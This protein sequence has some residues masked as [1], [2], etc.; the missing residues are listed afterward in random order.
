MKI[1]LVSSAVPLVFGGGRFISEWLQA[2]LRKRGHATEIVNIPSTD[3]PDTLLQQMAAF[4]SIDLSGYERVITFRPPAHVVRHAQKVV[5]FIHH[6]RIFYDL[7]DTPYRPVPDTVRWR[8][9]RAQLMQSDAAALSEARHV[10]SNSRVV[11]DRLARFNGIHAEVL[12]PPVKSSVS[13]GWSITSGNICWCK[14]W[15]IPARRSGCACVA[16]VLTRPMWQACATRR[17]VWV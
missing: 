7:W 1:G 10:F 13:A 2:E 17:S 9:L 4:R 16:R 5:W 8:A 6:I 12:Y 3:N 14:P 11:A 15:H